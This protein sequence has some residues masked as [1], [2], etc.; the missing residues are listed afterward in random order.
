MYTASVKNK[1]LLILCMYVY[2]VVLEVMNQDSSKESQVSYRCGIPSESHFSG[3]EIRCISPDD[4]PLHV[5]FQHILAFKLEDDHTLK[6]VLEHKR[7]DY[8][9][10]FILVNYE[11]QINLPD[12]FWDVGCPKDHSFCI[13]KKTDGEALLSDLLKTD[14]PGAIQV[15]VIKET[16]IDQPGKIA[17]Q[18]SSEEGMVLYTYV[19]M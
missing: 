1:P 3:L 17:N 2:Y 5:T 4:D 7:T 6:S 15:K 14:T 8:L 10:G 12:G 18:L 13:L 16:C 9:L 19:Y 11:E